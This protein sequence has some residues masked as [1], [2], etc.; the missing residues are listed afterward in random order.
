MLYREDIATAP[1]T[2]MRDVSTEGALCIVA[3]R[4]EEHDIDRRGRG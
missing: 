2:S 1:D 3:R 4:S